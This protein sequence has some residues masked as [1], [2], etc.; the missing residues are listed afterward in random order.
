MMV[1]DEDM[2]RRGWHQ[3]E[4]EEVAAREVCGG[5]GGW[6]LRVFDWGVGL[7]GCESRGVGLRHPGG[8]ELRLGLITTRIGLGRGFRWKAVAPPGSG[9]WCFE[10]KLDV[11]SVGVRFW[12]D[13]GEASHLS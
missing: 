2:R 8:A 11:F 12:H 13:E 4:S 10:V 7:D 3:A 1:I 5:P 9:W 6:A